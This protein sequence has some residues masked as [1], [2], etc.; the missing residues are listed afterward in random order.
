MSDVPK[1]HAK[2]MAF[3]SSFQ[4]KSDLYAPYEPHVKMV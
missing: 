1:G 4:R 2:G 3:F